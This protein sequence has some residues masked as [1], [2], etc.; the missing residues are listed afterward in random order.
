MTNDEALKKFLRQALPPRRDWDGLLSRINIWADATF[1]PGNGNT[2]GKAKHIEKEAVELMQA[3]RE[4]NPEKIRKEIADII[5]LATH[6]AHG[7]A[8]DLYEAV[9]EKF[10]I[11]K[12]R[13]WQ[14]PD[15]DG[16]IQ[17]VEE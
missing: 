10:E 14:A 1:G 13:K 2:Y 5:I 6:A 8:I 3:V 7:E 4:G 9:A 12:T 17:H 11:V 15:A 16:V